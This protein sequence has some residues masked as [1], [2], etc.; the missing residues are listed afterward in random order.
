MYHIAICDDDKE[1]ISYIERIIKQANCGDRHEIIF[2][3]YTSGEELLN[4]IDGYNQYDLLILDMQLGGIDGDE[5]A[6]VFRK[7]FPYAVLVFCSGVRPPSVKSFKATPFRYLLKT[8]SDKKFVSEMQDILTEVERNLQELYIVGHYRNNAIRVRI[9]NVLYIE[10]AKRGSRVVV[11]PR[12]EEAKFEG[13]ILLD[14]KLQ[15]LSEKFKELV[16]A[17]SSY[18]VN[19]NHVEYVDGNELILDSGERLSISRTYQ[20]TF[21]E[22]FTK[23]IANKYK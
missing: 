14:E 1:F 18:I 20:K 2:F 3:E 11:H 16:F 10:N 5:T 8:Y 6:R 9:R 7:K 22:A 21:R 13:L 23:S 19:M 12:A 17:H 15:E 4:N